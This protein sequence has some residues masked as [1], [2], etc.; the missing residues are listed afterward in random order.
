MKAK[1]WDDISIVSS[2]GNHKGTT[3]MKCRLS[4]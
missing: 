2:T 4:V 3:T 1:S